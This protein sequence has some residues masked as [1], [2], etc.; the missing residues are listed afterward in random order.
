MID[1]IENFPMSIRLLE[2]V[3]VIAVFSLILWCWDW[4]KTH[5]AAAMNKFKAIKDVL[6]SYFH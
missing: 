6:Y 3:I 1:I 5:K 2:V 4:C